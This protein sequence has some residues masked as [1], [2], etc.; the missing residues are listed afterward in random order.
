MRINKFISDTGFCSRREVDQLIQERRVKINGIVAGLGSQV[1]DGDDVRID[2]RALP[3]KKKN[4]VYLALNKPVGITSTTE[5]HVYGNIIDF[6]N[7]K[8]RIFPIGRLDKDSEGLILLTND[9]DIV[10]RILRAENHH[11]KEYLVTVDKQI[12]GDFIKRM[13]Q[14]VRV[15]GILTRKCEVERLSRN[16]FRIVLTE[17]RNR[18]IRKMCE[19][20]GFDVIK[21]KRIRIMNIHLENLQIGEW[22]NLN[23]FEL[24]ELFSILGYVPGQSQS[25]S[26]EVQV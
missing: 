19:F 5:R 24:N 11:E 1:M 26:D 4:Y 16:G 17:G 6:I 12:T 15:E 10:N 22:R 20:F 25:H 2:G 8:E 23:Q 21:L 9:G 3:N 18:Q 14:G 7:H 13:S